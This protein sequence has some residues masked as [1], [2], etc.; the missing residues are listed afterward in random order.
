[1]PQV[2]A[3]EERRLRELA[4]AHW[5]ERAIEDGRL[6]NYAHAAAVLGVTRA[7]VSQIVGSVT[8]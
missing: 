3:R 8:L 6:S 1:V 7:R 5:I 4:L 2:D